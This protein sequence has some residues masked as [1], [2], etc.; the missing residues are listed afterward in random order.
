[1]APASR[2]VI[3]AIEDEPLNAALLRAI[4][5]PAGYELHIE[6]TLADAR[7]WLEG[8]APALVLL[9][10]HL[11]DGDGLDLVP[12]LRASPATRDCRIL[13][14]S[15]SV[16]PEDRAAAELAGCDGFMAKPLR[17]HELLT[18]IEHLLG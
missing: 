14:L 2:A 7:D 12:E 8:D 10:R 6:P 3:L 11:P 16:Q 5:T 15:A 9:D 13:V 4:L 1:M 18:E 17:M